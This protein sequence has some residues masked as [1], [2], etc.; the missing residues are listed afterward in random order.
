MGFDISISLDLQMCEKTGRPYAWGPN[1]ERIYDIVLADFIIPAELRQYARGRGSIFYVYTNYF[2]ERDMC[3]ASTDMFQE[4]FP[5]WTDVEESK[6]YKD[7]SPSD[8]SEEDHDNFKA[9]LEWCSKHWGA[10]FR[11]SWSY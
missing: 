3:T 2:N 7:Y 9:L 4:E 6:E 11:V 5:S 10:S 1:L 8:W